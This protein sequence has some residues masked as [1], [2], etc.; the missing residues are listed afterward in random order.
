MNNGRLPAYGR[1]LLAAQKAGRNVPWL[2]I[3][4]DWGIGRAMPRVVATGDVPA[5]TFD[6]RL[7]RGLDCMVAHRGDGQRA[8]DLAEQALQYG[9]RICPVFD[10]EAGTCLS[11]DEIAAA[12][13]LGASA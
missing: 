1:E 2:L 4:L 13:G 11:T 8:V 6:L 7:V 5:H 9:A 3:A 10:L 12:R